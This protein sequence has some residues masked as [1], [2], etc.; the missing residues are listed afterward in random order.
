MPSRRSVLAGLAGTAALA[1]LPARAQFSLGNL[2]NSAAQVVGAYTTGEGDEIKMGESFYPDYLQKSGGTYPDRNGQEAL[3]SF[4][5]PL[6]AAADRKNLP[7]DITL[8]DN[9]QVNAWAL[10]GGKIAV[11]SELV[12][13]CTHPDELASVIAHEI[14]HA[15]HGH[16][17]NQIRNQALITSV[18]G[19]GKEALSGWMGGGALGSEVLTALEAPL[20]NL[21]LTGYSRTHEFEADAHILRI[22]QQT[23]NDPARADD[24]FRTLLRLN[25]E[26]ATATTSLFSTHPGTAERIARI[27]DAAIRADQ[28]SRT[29]SAPGWDTLKQLFP[30][31][32]A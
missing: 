28:P 10:P 9:K 25:P 6:L 17:L 1:A 14:G 5:Q 30:T 15:D 11:H 4:A 16:S 24:F 21:I 7:W 23:G 31:P 32:K 22:F 2:I 27:E 3:K 26:S 19:L 29:A 20:Y 13:Q 12:R 18:G 8:V